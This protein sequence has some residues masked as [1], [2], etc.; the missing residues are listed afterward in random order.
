[1]KQ[2]GYDVAVLHD[3]FVDRVMQ[4]GTVWGL[5]SLVN[6]KARE[7]GGGIHGIRQ[8]DVKGGNAVNLAHSLSTLG[9]RTLLI[10]HSDPEH[11]QLLR[12]SFAGTGAELRIKPLPAGLTVALEGGVNVM[13]GDPRG[14]GSFGP[15]LLDAEDWR[16][17]GSAKVVCTVNWAANRR[18]T[19]LLVA[20][21][22]RLPGRTIFLATADVRD[23]MADY[24]RLVRRLRREKL[25]DWLGLNEFEALATARALGA[26]TLG[27]REACMLIARET[28]ARV[29]VHTERVSFTCSGGR[30][31][32]ARTRRVSP[33]RLT[34][35]GDVWE[36]ASIYAHLKGMCD[37]ERLAF[38][39]A[40]A[41]LYVT[42]D[43]QRPPTSDE[44]IA[45]V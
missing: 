27:P 26:A 35:A 9:A 23:R 36:A 21:R 44:V 41:K 34:G 20:L 6:S 2:M 14:A 43:G 18:G 33:R 17:L 3:Y 5:V 13:L 24:G 32:A 29:D 38:A 4:C 16:G 10:T 37:R 28:G 11:V 42:S 22:G 45:A 19:E 8:M 7:G 12:N 40:A 30:L 15:E 25:A 39:N 31:E 1:V